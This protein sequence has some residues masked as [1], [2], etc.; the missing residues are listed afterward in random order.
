MKSLVSV[1]IPAYNAEQYVAAAIKSALA[2]TY[3]SMEV[4]VVDDGSTDGTAD[5]VAGF[6]RA[7]R[8]LRQPNAGVSAARN[9]GTTEAAGDLVGFLDADDEWLPRK[10]DV[11]VGRLTAR[12]EAVASFTGTVYVDEQTG[13][14]VTGT[15][16]IEPDMVEGLL[17]YSCIVGPPSSVLIRRVALSRVGGFDPRLSQCADWDM[18]IR[19]AEMGPLDVVDE[20]LVRYR[21][22]KSNM[23][24]DVGLLEADTLRT[25]RKFFAVSEH[26]EHYAAQRERIY[27]NQLMILSGSYLRAA[28]LGSSVRCLTEA[29]VRHPANAVRALGLPLRFL[30]RRFSGTGGA[31]RAGHSPLA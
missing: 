15:C 19:L 13:T 27:S 31:D 21:V 30:R 17:L 1:I 24:R 22:H 18:W 25:L 14:E 11:Q 23:S 10:V 20:P 12:P 2:Q 26:R 6:G 16:R 4:I 9:R 8:Y 3:P 5:I 29:T 28:A 7:V